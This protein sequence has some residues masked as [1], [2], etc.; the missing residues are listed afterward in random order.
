MLDV[1]LAAISADT[2]TLIN[3]YMYLIR[4]EM[5]WDISRTTNFSN[6]KSLIFIKMYSVE[7]QFL[8]IAVRWHSLIHFKMAK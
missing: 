2:T 7:M 5:L 4:Y 3:M 6:H 8:L 1:A